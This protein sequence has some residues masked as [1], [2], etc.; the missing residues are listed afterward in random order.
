MSDAELVELVAG[1][2]DEAMS[3]LYR[4]HRDVVVRFARGMTGSLDAAVDIAQDVFVA[5][6]LDAGRYD[7]ERAA[8]TTYL[9][10]M[11]RNH[12]RTWLRRQ[13]RWLSFQ[14]LASAGS[15]P[16]RPADPFARLEDAE[17]AAQ[18]RAALQRIPA[19]YREVMILC[20]LH[21]L[22]YDQTA[23]IVGASVAAVRSR[24]HRGRRLLRGKLS[25]STSESSSD[26]RPAHY[27]V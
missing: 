24:L 12:S 22:S 6:T 16:S 13:R 25:V 15:Q 2:D 10:A 3:A 26:M 9:Y 4:R 19:R 20:D 11:A 27:V 8:F 7:A 17:L 23:R 21:D 5:L 18:V 1:G 14:R